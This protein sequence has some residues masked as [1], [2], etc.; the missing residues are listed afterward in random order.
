VR[1]SFRLGALDE[2][3]VPVLRVHNAGRSSASESRPSGLQQA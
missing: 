3:V 2:E 1:E